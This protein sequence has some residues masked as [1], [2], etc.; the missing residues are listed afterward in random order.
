M[1][2]TVMHFEN[3]IDQIQYYT[4][5]YCTKEKPKLISAF[6]ITFIKNVV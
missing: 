6:D 4:T 5:L 1:N 2:C 3:K